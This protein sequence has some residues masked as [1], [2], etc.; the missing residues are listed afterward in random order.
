MKNIL[1]ILSFVFFISSCDSGFFK[2]NST[3]S[4]LESQN[5][6][7]NSSIKLFKGKIDS[8]YEIVMELTISNG[9]INGRYYYVSKGID[10][11]LKGTID[12]ANNA[13]VNE[14]NDRGSLTGVFKGSISSIG[15]VGTWEKPDGSKIL[16]LS[17]APYYGEYKG[18][19]SNSS[20]S[21]SFDVNKISG[22]Y[23]TNSSSMSQG[24][25]INY[26][27]NKEFEF[28]ITVATQDECMGEDEGKAAV[29]S[30]GVALFNIINFDG[31]RRSYKFIFNT[32]N[33]TV[34]V[35][36]GGNEVYHGASCTFEGT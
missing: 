23:S 13:T 24:L 14:F 32:T 36:E 9:T 33:G 11:K 31:G 35:T 8:K 3:P 16:D 34:Q 30:D 18:E 4:D 12:N 22:D 27:G 2:N 1:L 10:M 7:L 21:S 26:L 17:L 5:S 19:V 15:F 20:S 6:N 28:F 25:S 29:S